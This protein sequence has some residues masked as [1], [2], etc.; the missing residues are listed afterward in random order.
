[1]LLFWVDCSNIAFIFISGALLSTNTTHD[2]NNDI[3]VEIVKYTSREIILMIENT[4]VACLGVFN[5]NL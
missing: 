1:M 4:A 2:D 5:Q 3:V